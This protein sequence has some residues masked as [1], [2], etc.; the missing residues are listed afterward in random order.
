[1]TCPAGVPGGNPS[2]LLL[3]GL[4]ALDDKGDKH[5]ILLK[6]CHGMAHLTR[7]I[8]VLAFLPGLECILHEMTGRAEIRVFP[9]VMIITVCQD[10]P[11]DR[12]QK[13]QNHDRFFVL[14][15]EVNENRGLVRHAPASMP[16][17]EPEE[18]VE[19]KGK[20]KPHEGAECR[21]DREDNNKG[22]PYNDAL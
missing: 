1:M 14:F 15:Y 13:K 8:P 17:Q 2:V 3:D 16:A 5:L 21:K 12:D 18:F 9:R 11:D 20:N 22:Q 19:E 7:I 10:A 6:K 4:R